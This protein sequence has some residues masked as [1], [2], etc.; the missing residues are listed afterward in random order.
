M[1]KYESTWS[2]L[3]PRNNTYNHTCFKELNPDKTPTGPW[4][5][6]DP[7]DFR[8]MWWKIPDIID[9][10][11]FYAKKELHNILGYFVIQDT[12]LTGLC[13]YI[14]YWYYGD[15]NRYVKKIYDWCFNKELTKIKELDVVHL[16]NNYAT[17]DYTAFDCKYAEKDQK[18][19]C[20]IFIRRY[21]DGRTEGENQF[22]II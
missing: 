2:E 5:N 10:K 21:Q 12:T 1:S 8:N 7:N 6:L 15:P 14:V 17:N 3:D 20:K 16:L 13:W 19:Y 4:T 11:K 22:N 9:P 18:K